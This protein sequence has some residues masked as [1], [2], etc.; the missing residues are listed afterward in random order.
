[1]AMTS[2]VFGTWGPSTANHF[3]ILPAYSSCLWEGVAVEIRSP[4]APTTNCRSSSADPVCPAEEESLNGT[5]VLGIDKGVA[6]HIS[7]IQSAACQ[8]CDTEE[9]TFG[10]DYIQGVDA[11]AWGHP[12]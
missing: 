6:I 1:M 2:T 4:R 11:E 9:I 5:D 12:R 8:R 3:G 7:S 10:G